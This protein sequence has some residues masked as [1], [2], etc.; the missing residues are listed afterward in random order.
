MEFQEPNPNARIPEQ[1][2]AS[3]T[4]ATQQKLSVEVQTMLQLTE[5]LAF[6]K[7]ECN[8]LRAERDDK[9]R[10]I[11]NTADKS[12]EYEDRIK[13]LEREK[14]QFQRWWSDGNSEKHDLQKEIEDLKTKLA[15]TKAGDKAKK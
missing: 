12:E 13:T 10:I 1:Q 7:A 2:I 3:A 14:D 9:Q 4:F 6:S 8:R 5:D 15:K 11:N